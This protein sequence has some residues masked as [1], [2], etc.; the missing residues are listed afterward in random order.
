[1]TSPIWS[2]FLGELCPVRACHSLTNWDLG[3][4]STFASTANEVESACMPVMWLSATWVVSRMADQSVSTIRARANPAW[5]AT[6]SGETDRANSS[7]RAASAEAVSNQR[8]RT[9]ECL[10][11]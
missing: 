1:M 6:D 2:K 8:G 3:S 4:A 7:A 9:Y 11:S 5:K 10:T